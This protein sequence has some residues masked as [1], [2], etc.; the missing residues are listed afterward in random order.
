[1]LKKLRIA[2]FRFSIRAEDVL[3]LPEYK[4]STLRGAFGSA[5]K[6]IACTR[7][8]DVCAGG[9]ERRE[10]CAYGYVFES[11]VP[12]DAKVLKNLSDIPRPFVIEPPLDRKTHYGIGES[13][14]WRVVLIGNAVQ[15]IPYF[16]LAFKALGSTGIG[17][18]R[19]RFSLESVEAVNPLDESSKSV[20]SSEDGALRSA[21]LSI[22]FEDLQNHA[23]VLPTESIT[24]RFLTPTRIKHQDQYVTRPDFHV[25]VRAV[26]RRVSSLYYFHCGEQW[27]TDYRGIIAQA[28]NIQTARVETRWV[29]W[30][31]YSARQDKK[32]E[33]GGFIG[34]ATYAGDLKPF[35]PLLLVGQL[36]HV[37]K[38]CVF[39]NGQ[40]VLVG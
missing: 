40:Y 1:M 25:L 17:K 20:Y 9:C 7:G 26:L 18:G 5:F 38:A 14:E 12:T 24:I 15:H 30:E 21:D 31:R 28:Q 3:V 37:G 36:V 22:G 2:V 39:G 34:E 33:L 6:R 8:A 32:I 16:V 27:K 19:G 10:R 13:L 29:D 23:S 35:L 4:G 11:P